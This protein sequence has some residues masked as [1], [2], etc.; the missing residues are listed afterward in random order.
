MERRQQA[1]TTRQKSKPIQ[2]KVAKKVGEGWDR[3]TWPLGPK[4]GQT[5][6]SQQGNRSDYITRANKSKQDYKSNQLA[7]M[8]AF[9][10]DTMSDMEGKQ[11]DKSMAPCTPSRKQGSDQELVKI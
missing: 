5:L 9:K 7:E 4:G 11:S 1:T 8:N 3:S 2:V 10:P 6:L